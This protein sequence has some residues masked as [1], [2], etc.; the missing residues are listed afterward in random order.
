MC[1]LSTISVP[2]LW[3]FLTQVES[4]PHWL[5]ARCICWQVSLTWQKDILDSF[6]CL[7]SLP[8]FACT[9]HFAK[10][11]DLWTLTSNIA[12]TLIV[13]IYY[14][15]LKAFFFPSW[16]NALI[17]FLLNNLL[18]LCSFSQMSLRL[19]F[20]EKT[21][22]RVKEVLASFFYHLDSVTTHCSLPS[23]CR[24]ASSKWQQA[25]PG[26]ILSPPLLKVLLLKITRHKTCALL[27]FLASTLTSFK[28]RFS[29]PC[30]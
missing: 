20:Y 3:E 29:S 4:F 17:V 11:F 14:V 24:K 19:C 1:I 22:P 6:P 7:P 15:R 12:F 2:Q 23:R 25:E 16:F 26:W 21:Q 8:S 10:Y 28:F 9:W 13:G 30:P 18:G 27:L 5:F